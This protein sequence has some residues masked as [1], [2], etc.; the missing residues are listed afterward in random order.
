MLDYKNYE[1]KTFNITHQEEGKSSLL[2][3]SY[4]ITL[5]VEIDKLIEKNYDQ[6]TTTV[7]RPKQKFE[8]VITPISDEQS[9]QTQT[10]NSDTEVETDSEQ[11]CD[12]ESQSSTSPEKSSSS[13]MDLE[14]VIQSAI[15]SEIQSNYT[16]I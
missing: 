8:I 13:N 6:K 2:S 16:S 9:N 7:S 14:S 11:D 3:G 1:R 5:Q 15:Q 10:E 4:V 12:Q